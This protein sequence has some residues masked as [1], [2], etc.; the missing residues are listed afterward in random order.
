MPLTGL[1]PTRCVSLKRWFFLP[2]ING[3]RRP[4]NWMCGWNS[5]RAA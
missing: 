2:T 5:T 1:S 4:G 3:P